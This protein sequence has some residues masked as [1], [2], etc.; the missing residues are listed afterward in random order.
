MN[1][2]NERRFVI[3]TRIMPLLHDEMQEIVVNLDA[4]AMVHSDR[5][6]DARMVIWF[7]GGDDSVTCLGRPQSFV[8]QCL[9]AHEWVRMTEVDAA[10]R[11]DQ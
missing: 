6:N 8:K 3:L 9:S 4:I 11:A 5:K 10:M 1:K 7:I 2:T